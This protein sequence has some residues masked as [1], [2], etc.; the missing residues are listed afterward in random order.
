MK[1]IYNTEIPRGSRKSGRS[2]EYA[3]IITDFLA[4]G[5][6]TAEVNH[7]RHGKAVLSVYQG[8][9]CCKKRLGCA[10]NVVKRGDRLFLARNGRDDNAESAS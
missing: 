5:Q 3:S 4:S 1:L 8:L 9:F 6:E 7:K 10:V 2:S